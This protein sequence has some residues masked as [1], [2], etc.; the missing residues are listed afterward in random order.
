MPMALTLTHRAPSS[1]RHSASGPRSLL[2][3][4]ARVGGVAVRWVGVAVAGVTRVGSVAAVVVLRASDC[5]KDG[6]NGEKD[7]WVVGWSSGL[8]DGTWVS[9]ITFVVRGKSFVGDLT[10]QLATYDCLDHF[11]WFEFWVWCVEAK[12]SERGL[13][14]WLVVCDCLRLSCL[15]RKL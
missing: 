3:I 11:D 9:S 13:E 12:I 4:V 7:L 10:L 14:S 5:G 15:Q 6:Q 1:W 8:C 2:K